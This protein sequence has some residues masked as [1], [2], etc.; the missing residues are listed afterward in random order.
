MQV[1]LQNTKL[2]DSSDT[3]VNMWLDR[4]VELSEFYADHWM[5]LP[6]VDPDSIRPGTTHIFP[7]P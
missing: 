7:P 5:E 4:L 1:Y 6:N 3:E 2:E